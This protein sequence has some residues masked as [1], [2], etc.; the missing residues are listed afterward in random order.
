[1]RIIEV[2]E[3]TKRY[4]R[5]TAVDR[6][7]FTVEKGQVFGFLGPNGSGKTT[8]IGLLLGIVRPDGGAI[9]LFGEHGMDR[10]HIARRRIGATLET[11]NFYPYLSG[12]DNLRVVAKIKEVGEAQISAALDA[13]GLSPRA[14]DRFSKYSL[15]MKQRLAIAGA[16]MGNPELVILDEP[17]NGLDPEGMREIR[18]IIRG[19]AAQGRTIFV[20]SHL[21]YEVERTCTHV[22]IIKKGRILTQGSLDRLVRGTSLARV[23]SADRE[24]LLRAV[25]ECPAVVRA[26]PEGEDVLLELRD[27]DLAALNRFLAERNVF[28]S[29]LALQRQSLEDVF[30]DLTGDRPDLAPGEAAA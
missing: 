20:S 13:V 14:H 24:A 1:M 10:L 19:L 17:A 23:R 21:L 5:L 2:S 29:R 28:V 8:T 27:E 22:A 12:R 18:E 9:R 16:M 26:E 30:I 4:G 3:L 25:G 11:P 6:I 15:G 7:S